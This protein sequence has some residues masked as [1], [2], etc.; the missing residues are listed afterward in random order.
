MAQKPA[1]LCK[2][3]AQRPATSCNP[4][5]TAQP[6]SQ[7]SESGVCPTSKHHSRYYTHVHVHVHLCATYVQP[8]CNVLQVHQ[9]HTHVMHPRASSP[10]TCVIHP[11][12]VHP[13]ALF[14]HPCATH[15]LCPL[16]IHPPTQ[17]SITTLHPCQHLGPPHGFHIRF[18][19]HP[20]SAEH[21]NFHP[22]NQNTSSKSKTP[23]TR[24]GG[25]NL[26]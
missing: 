17:L 1:T 14:M 20:F 25:I 6:V 2:T 19:L 11:C 3:T 26:A 10:H 23:P 24:L 8:L 16:Y 4:P 12:A 15:H 22:L 13:R 21:I 9:V 7:V 5:P 18:P